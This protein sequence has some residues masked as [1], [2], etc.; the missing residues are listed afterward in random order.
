[1]R[2]GF[3]ALG[4]LLVLGCGGDAGHPDT[5]VGA[6]AAVPTVEGCTDY[7]T[8]STFCA[9]ALCDEDTMSMNYDSLG[10]ALQNTCN[11]TC[12]DAQLQTIVSPTAWEC[13]FQSSCRQVYEHDA[14]HVAA[15]YRCH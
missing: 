11:S 14:C 5:G 3:A 9:V 12:T 6:G 2:R 13:L 8:R 15:T 4:L 7:S 1:M 10:P